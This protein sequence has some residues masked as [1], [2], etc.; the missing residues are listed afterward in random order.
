MVDISNG[1]NM[2]DFLQ[3]LAP[4][5]YGFIVGFFWN[6]IFTL[7]RRIYEEAKLARKQWS[8]PN[9]DRNV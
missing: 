4:F 7:A 1:V 9:G 8:N 6:P 3:A 2:N 5:V